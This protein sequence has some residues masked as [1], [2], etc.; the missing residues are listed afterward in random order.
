MDFTQGPYRIFLRDARI[1]HIFCYNCSKS[2]RQYNIFFAS[3]CPVFLQLAGN[4]LLRC[5]NRIFILLQLRF[6]FASLEYFFATTIFP[7]CIIKFVG[8]FHRIFLLRYYNSTKNLLR[9][10]RRGLWQE[11]LASKNLLRAS[12]V[13]KSAP[14]T[15]ARSPA[16]S[17]LF[18]FEL[19][20]ATM[21][22]KRLF[23]L[24]RSNFGIL[25]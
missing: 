5:Y 6:D 21:K 23:L 10:L 11:I 12:I 8:R 4:Y 18:C 2:L 24:H 7:V 15:P 13:Q 20:F 22:Q 17:A 1:E 3:F 9:R 19:F 16:R 25:V 14:T